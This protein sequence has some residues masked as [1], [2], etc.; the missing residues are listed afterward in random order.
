V[1]QAFYAFDRAVE[2]FPDRADFYNQLGK[3]SLM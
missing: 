1:S 2:F 3:Y